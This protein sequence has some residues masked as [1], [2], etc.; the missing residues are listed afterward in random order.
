MEYNRLFA[1]KDEYQLV[2]G[3]YEGRGTLDSVILR[4]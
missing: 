1:D 2:K 3:W 4:R